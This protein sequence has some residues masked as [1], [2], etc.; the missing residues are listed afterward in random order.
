MENLTT[1]LEIITELRLE[2]KALKKS[3]KE[4]GESSSYWYNAYSELD[5]ERN[6]RELTVKLTTEN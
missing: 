6:Q 3:D 2:N 1:L 4:K 5:K